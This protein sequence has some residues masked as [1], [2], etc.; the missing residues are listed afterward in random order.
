M[1]K[2]PRYHPYSDGAGRHFWQVIPLQ[3]TT[4]GF[5]SKVYAYTI[6]ELLPED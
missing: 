4:E 5:P 2:Q 3:G 6:D 1:V